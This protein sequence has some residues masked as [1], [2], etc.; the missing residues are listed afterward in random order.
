MGKSKVNYKGLK[1]RMNIF[2]T[3]DSEKKIFIN[4][5]LPFVDGS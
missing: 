2:Y 5:F 1:L 4:V 3:L